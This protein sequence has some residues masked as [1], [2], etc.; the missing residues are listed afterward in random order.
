MG[1]HS[2]GGEDRDVSGAEAVATGSKTYSSRKTATVNKEIAE[3]NKINRES[4]KGFIQKIAENTL[5]GKL[6]KS[7][8]SKERNLK[9]RKAFIKKN[10]DKFRDVGQFTD[11]FI[12]SKGFKTQIDAMGYADR[13]KPFG[14]GSGK[15]TL[16]KKDTT[17]ST[18]SDE[19]PKVI[20]QMD[21]SDVK[22]KMIVASGPT[23]PEIDDQIIGTK[24]KRRGK[25]TTILTSAYGV[26]DDATLGKKT[27]LG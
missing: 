23:S 22:S 10:P 8:W 9:S 12:L 4:R 2:S 13:N 18:K 11:E 15:T 5:L 26:D 7:K 6:S 27:L 17:A 19:Q 1:G 21:N 20:S 25:K 14:E 3:Q 16:I 24:I